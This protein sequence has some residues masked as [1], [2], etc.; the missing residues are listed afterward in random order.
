M[1]PANSA[2]KTFSGMVV[3]SG[4]TTRAA[5]YAQHSLGFSPI[6]LVARNKSTVEEIISSFP[7]DYNLVHVED[8]SNVRQLPS[9]IVSTVPADRPVDTSMRELLVSVLRQ[10]RQTGRSRIFLEMAYKPRHTPLMGLA[11]D[12]GW[13]SIPGLEVLTSQGYY[14]FQLW[15]GITPLFS[16]ARAAVLGE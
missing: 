7:Q 4:G 1:L 13:I 6:Y 2:D 11:E 10:P 8:A 15:T 9:V 16:D 3:G 12:S 14:Q 5:I